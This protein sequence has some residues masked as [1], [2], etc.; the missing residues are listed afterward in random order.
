[1]RRFLTSQRRMSAGNLVARLEQDHVSG[2]KLFGRDHAGVSF[3]HGHGFGRKHVPDRVQRLLGLSFL[4][5]AKERV[6]DNDA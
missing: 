3:P 5:K 6:D 1:M 4:N 2:N